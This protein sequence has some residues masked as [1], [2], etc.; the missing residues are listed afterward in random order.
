V[1]ARV[2]IDKIQIRQAYSFFGGLRAVGQPLWSSRIEDRQP[3]LSRPGACY[4]PR[5]IF[6]SGLRR[7]LL[8]HARPN[9]RSRD[10]ARKVDSRFRGGLAIFQ[11]AQPWGRFEPVFDT[12]EWDVA[13][14]DSASIP[15]KWISAGGRTLHIV[16]SGEDSFSVWEFAIH[17][18]SD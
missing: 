15:A 4:R 7:V 8:V 3:V 10:A 1:L 12:A 2:P 11:A 16:F 17:P 18:A 6:D 13:P 9:I 5:P 14:G